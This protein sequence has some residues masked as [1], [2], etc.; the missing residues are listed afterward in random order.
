MRIAALLALI[1]V[2]LVTAAAL[3]ASK[4]AFGTRQDGG[5]IAGVPRDPDRV[6]EK[7]LRQISAREPLGAIRGGKQILFGDLH[8]H[9]TFSFDAYSISLPMYQGEGSHPPADACDFARFCSDLDFWSINDHAEGL[10]P[11]QWRETRETVRQ[12]NAVAGD[13]DD[14]DLVTFLGW[15]WTQIGNT[16]DSHY[17]HKNV[18][19]LDTEEGAVPTRPISSREQLFPGGSDPYSTPMRIGLIVAAPGG[20]RQAYLDFARFLADRSERAPCPKGVAV[21][22]LPQDCQESAPTPGELFAKLDDWGF[23]ALV[24]PHG[25]TW[26]FYTPPLT[27]WDRQLAAHDDPEKREF[28]FEVF[29]GHG[30]T[31]EYRSFRAIEID[32]DGAPRCPRPSPG[33]VPECWRA[34]EI[35]R[36]RCREA[37]ERECEARAEE[38]RAHHVAAGDAGHLAVPGQEIEDWLDSGQCSDCY[39]PAY[40]YRPGGSVQYALA[41]RSFDGEAPKRFRFGLIASSDVHTARPGTGYKEIQR[42]RMTDAGLGNLGPPPI[43]TRGESAPRSV[44]LE[45]DDFRT[46]NFERFA[47]FFGAGGLV[48]AHSSGRDR[49]SIWEALQ[50]KE[51]YGTSGDR[52]L[53]WF[54][55]LHEDGTRLPMGG[56]LLQTDAPSFEVTAIGAFAQKPG[57][58]PDALQALGEKRLARLCGGECYH[59]SDSRKRIDRIE[60][61]RIRPQ[62]SPDEPIGERIEDPWRVLPCPAAGEGCRVR[63]RDPDFSQAERD[64]VYYVRAIQGAS[65]TMNAGQL[66]CT[67]DEAGACVSVEPCRASEPT[68]YEDDCLEQAEERAWSSPIFVDHP[69]AASRPDPE[70]PATPPTDPSLASADPLR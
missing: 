6:R 44:A 17:G 70:G 63:F 48:A 18:I 26:G 65:A 35:I 34:G 52:I 15:E 19:L 16:K 20:R 33:Y 56:S 31:E 10:T 69:R 51:V 57:C 40:N 36:V 41:H 55:L 24:I 13:A 53:L 5:E 9:T 12:C 22:N 3:I 21:R 27:S 11:H 8:V 25:N 43:L 59:P 23:P 2:A 14:P 7:T 60:V 67:R 4:G 38:A 49:H 42:R 61:V 30:N 68:A 29:S 45:E 37:G 46:P 50:R 66:R 58:P 62:A 32:E 1:L 28:L 39:M 54:D 64:S 47:S